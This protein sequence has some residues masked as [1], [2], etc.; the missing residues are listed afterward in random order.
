MFEEEKAKKDFQLCG[1]GG[2]SHSY[3]TG[4]PNK[5]GQMTYGHKHQESQNSGEE[6]KQYTFL[7]CKGARQLGAL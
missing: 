1:G 5:N 7:E 3:K 2:Y 6:R 4:R